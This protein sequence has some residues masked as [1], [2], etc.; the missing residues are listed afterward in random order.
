M[1]TWVDYIPVLVIF[2]VMAIIFK[3][4]FEYL[5]RKRLIEKGL[6]G[7][8]AHTLMQGI[9][10]SGVPSSLKWGIVLVLV[11]GTFLVMEML[12]V[13]VSSEAAL[14]VLLVAAGVGLLTFYALSSFMGK[15][16]PA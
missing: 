13:R 12:P 15:K 8:D 4:Y 10:Y 7:D 5:T 9:T 1:D 6:T 14:G 3:H 11:G 16:S 2:P